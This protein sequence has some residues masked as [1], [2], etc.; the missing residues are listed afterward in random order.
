VSS[1]DIRARLDH[2]VIDA[3]GHMLEYIPVY[4]DF[5]KQVAGPKMVERYV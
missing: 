5:L 3:D 4:L 1:N 2:L